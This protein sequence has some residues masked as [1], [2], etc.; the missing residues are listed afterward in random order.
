MCCWARTAVPIRGEHGFLEASG[1]RCL[2]I[3]NSPNGNRQLLD[4]YPVGLCLTAPGYV[5]TRV[6]RFAIVTMRVG[7]FARVRAMTGTEQQCTGSYEDYPK[8][9]AAVL[10]REVSTSF[11]RRASRMHAHFRMPV[12]GSRDA[13]S[14]DICEL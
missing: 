1:E 11:E 12:S 13:C 5:G 8:M 2:T 9:I 6:R 3:G 14:E 7:Q 4:R 10:E